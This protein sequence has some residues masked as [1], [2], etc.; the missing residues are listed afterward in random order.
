MLG[1]NKWRKL[2][3]NL[4]AATD[5]RQNMLLTFGGAWSNH[6]YATAAAGR[7]IG[8]DTIGIIRGEHPERLS[9]TLEFAQECGMQLKFISRS[10]YRLKSSADFI[11][12]L[13]DEF[14]DFY[15]LPEGGSNSLALKGVAELLDEID[16]GFDVITTACGTAATLAGLAGGINTT[17]TAQ[18]YA[19]LKDGD[20]LNSEVEHFLSDAAI[21]AEGRWDIDTSYHFGGYAK[22]D[23][24][25]LDFI[26]GFKNEFGITLDAVYTGKMFYGLF[27]QIKKQAFPRGTTV[28][29]V[30]TGGLQGNAGFKELRI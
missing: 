23:Q 24:V 6:I 11:Q 13:H 8:F 15:L 9:T 7:Y 22:T 12:N 2:K 27:D 10:E 16:I 29:A 19:V 21:K 28:V 1:G 14:G 25:L 4:Q 17:Q 3:Y 5:A 20:F 18:G 26:L 30:H